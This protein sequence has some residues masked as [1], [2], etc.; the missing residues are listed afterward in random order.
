[1]AYPRKTGSL[2]DNENVPSGAAIPEPTAAD[3]ERLF[4]SLLP[5]LRNN[6]TIAQSAYE[7]VLRLVGSFEL[8]C[9][10]QADGIL[11]FNP[12]AGKSSS[13]VAPAAVGQTAAAADAN[14]ADAA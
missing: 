1:V 4:N 11:V 7:F 10:M 12:S 6:L 13:A 8:A 14:S 2:T 3:V 5:R 9:D